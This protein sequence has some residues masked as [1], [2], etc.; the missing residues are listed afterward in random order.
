MSQYRELET[1]T[2]FSS[3]LD[4]ETQAQLAYGERLMEMLKQPVHQ[5]MSMAD[6]VISLVA[7]ENGAFNKIPVADLKAVQKTL[8]EDFKVQHPEII[9]QLNTTKDLDDELKQQ[10]VD[11]A[12]QIVAGMDQKTAR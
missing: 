7:A 12:K 11:A 10:I 3:D 1:F 9:D 6:Q 8:L 5:P 2:Q 4:D